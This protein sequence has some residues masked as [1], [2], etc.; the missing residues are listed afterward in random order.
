MAIKI[1]GPRSVRSKLERMAADLKNDAARLLSEH[2]DEESLADA[3]LYH[4]N[5]LLTVAS[6]CGRARD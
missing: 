4:A 3:L 5:R 1:T 2:P 6:Y